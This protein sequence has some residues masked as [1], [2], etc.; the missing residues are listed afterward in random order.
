[1][2]TENVV[3][4]L[5][6]AVDEMRRERDELDQQIHVIETTLLRLEKGLGVAPAKARK[7]APQPKK[8]AAAAAAVED[9]PSDLPSRKKPY[10]S[11]AA[12]KAA[13]ERMRQ[14]WAKRRKT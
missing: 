14:Y 6:Q 5:R 3:A 2:V 13:A 4:Q 10:W 7:A 12:R 8:G 1:M 11:P 9:E